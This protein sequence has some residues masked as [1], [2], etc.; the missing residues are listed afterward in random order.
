MRTTIRIASLNILEQLLGEKNMDYT[1]IVGREAI[2]FEAR[3]ELERKVKE[4]ISHGWKPLGGV[5]V[6]KI[7]STFT[8]SGSKEFVF[9]QAMIK[10]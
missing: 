3:K 10:E 7:D 2:C 5:S 4:Y 9:A 6:S 1:V 8:Y